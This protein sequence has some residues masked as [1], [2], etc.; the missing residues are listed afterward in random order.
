MKNYLLPIFV[1]LIVGCGNHRPQQTYDEM[2]NDIVQNFNRGTTD[3]DS[4]LK[5]FVRKT[6]ADSVARQYS[7]PAMKEEMMLNLIS[8]YLVAGQVDNAQHL[9]DNMLEYAEQEYGQVCQM[10]AM[11]YF[12]KA[13]LYEQTGDLDNAIKMMQK[14][15]EV[16]K[17]LPKNQYNQYN[18]AKEFIKRWT[19]DNP[20]IEFKDAKFLEA[21]LSNSNY[22]LD[23]N[24][25]GQISKREAA[26]VKYLHIDKCEI[27][28][29][30]EI[31]Y[32]T[33]LK[34]LYCYN[35]QLS[36]LD[37][38]K[39]TELTYLNCRYNQL[40]SLDISKNTEL[41]Y[42]SCDN[43]QLSSIN[44]STNTALIELYCYN[45]QLTSLDLSKNTA[46]T[47]LECYNNQLTLLD[48]SRNKA[49]TRLECGYNQLI[50]LDLSKNTALTYL[51]CD[52]NQLTSLNLSKNTALI[53]LYCGGNQLT[54]LD[55]SNSK[56]LTLLRCNGNQL[57]SV[58]IYKYNIM[59]EWLMDDIIF[60]YGN[61]IT[62]IE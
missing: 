58:R 13:H 59:D 3:G 9:Y 37:L 12:E 31:C 46:L 10:T 23:R 40:T 42:L 51:S 1:L 48:V 61:I 44:V 8:D 2:L 49:L 39:N 50:S 33:A 20:I 29:M 14:S 7:N 18:D 28:R 43:N 41:T 36:S 24:G 53:T 6:Q 22:G 26:N 60:D 4:V 45:N 27:T 34:K 25:D 16:F 62:Y 35:N 54:S 47:E 21:L 52:T 5:T 38:S 57:T 30:D 32:F 56:E 19:S 11:A 15:A 17:K 55:V